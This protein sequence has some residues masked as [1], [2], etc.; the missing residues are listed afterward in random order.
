MRS[1]IVVAVVLQ[2]A[3]RIIEIHG[4]FEFGDII[5]FKRKCLCKPFTYKHFAIYV[6]NRTMDGDAKQQPDCMFGKLSEQ[7]EGTKENYLDQEFSEEVNKA[8]HDTNIISTRISAMITKCGVY[9]VLKNNCE[10]LATYVRYGHS[11]S[12]QPG[13][14]AEIFCKKKPKDCSELNAL[15]QEWRKMK[16]TDK[17][18][19]LNVQ[20]PSQIMAK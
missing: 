17:Y 8:A 12:R 1:L 13:T 3:I 9:N 4:N 20:P 10:H 7:G 16:K 5:S 18:V 14:F 19:L 11:I 2:L 6:G 15:V